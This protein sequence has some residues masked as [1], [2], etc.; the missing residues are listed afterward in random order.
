MFF[1]V[2]SECAFLLYS[3]IAAEQKR[4]KVIETTHTY[5]YKYA[6]NNHMFIKKV[7]FVVDTKHRYMSTV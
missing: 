6:H 3:F 7:K 1:K 2:S 4:Q 5:V